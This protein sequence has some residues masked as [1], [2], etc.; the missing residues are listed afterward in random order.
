MRVVSGALFVALLENLDA[1]RQL[2]EWL[3]RSRLNHVPRHSVVERALADLLV[4]DE[5][6]ESN[7]WRNALM[8]RALSRNAVEL[9]RREL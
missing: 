5:G 6:G 4:V 7:I 9:S 3:E 2:A 1:R 8:L